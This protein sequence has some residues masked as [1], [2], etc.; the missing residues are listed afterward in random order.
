MV[1]TVVLSIQDLKHRWVYMVE[2]NG[3]NFWYRISGKKAEGF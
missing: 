3:F 1:V 2:L